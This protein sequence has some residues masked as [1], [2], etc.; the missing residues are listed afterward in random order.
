MVRSRPA[1]A[2]RCNGKADGGSPTS[3]IASTREP[4]SPA[5]QRRQQRPGSGGSSSS[6]QGSSEWAEDGRRPQEIDFF[7]PLRAPTAASTGNLT[8]M[9]D[10]E[11]AAAF[12]LGN[13]F[14]NC[15]GQ[16][17]GTNFV[18]KTLE[19][20]RPSYITE[21]LRFHGALNA[22]AEVISV[23]PSMQTMEGL[24]GYSGDTSDSVRGQEAEGVI[25]QLELQ[26]E[27]AGSG[28]A[29]V[30]LK[31]FDMDTLGW[32]QDVVKP[33]RCAIF[34]CGGCC[35]SSCNR[36]SCF[37]PG[38]SY[39]CVRADQARY[40]FPLRNWAPEE[41]FRPE[42]EFYTELHSLVRKRCPRFNMPKVF[43]TAFEDNG[44]T[45]CC[46]LRFC[47][48]GKHSGSHGMLLLED[49]SE[50]G[51]FPCNDLAVYGPGAVP[52]QCSFAYKA[53]IEAK[54]ASLPP[55]RELLE[56]LV[57]SL[58]ELHAGFWRDVDLPQVVAY[59]VK[60]VWHGR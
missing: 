6:S 51:W 19:E 26:Y 42:F 3:S 2:S 59:E 48:F 39:C 4:A 28:P 43:L 47:I 53:G 31:R 57:L 20:L 58:A 30:V 22:D 24:S 44:D 15:E 21:H 37:V 25:K 1:S 36:H 56:T 5:R 14:Q 50:S 35:V 27:P 45:D 60:S 55:A 23:A 41:T 40:S 11:E 29:S 38:Y 33:F 52:M 32:F 7:V 16:A 8:P 49:L 12:G 46:T 34:C 10:R 9:S 17:S 18:P 54:L 13:S